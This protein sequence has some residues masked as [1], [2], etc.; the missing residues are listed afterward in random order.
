MLPA[1]EEKIHVY[2]RERGAG[3]FRRAI[4]LPDDI[5]PDDVRASYRDGVL[6]VSVAR[7]E[8][9]QPKRIAVE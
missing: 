3:T 6:R 7:Q 4:A 5:N 1:N 8:A 9:V 2:S